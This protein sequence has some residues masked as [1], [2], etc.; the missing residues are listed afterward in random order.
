[1]NYFFFFNWD[2]HQNLIILKQQDSNEAG[3]QYLV[4]ARKTLS[5]SD[6]QQVPTQAGHRSR[7]PQALKFLFQE[8]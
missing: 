8:Q 6:L 1:M 7:E 2:V 4:T 3:R 5:A